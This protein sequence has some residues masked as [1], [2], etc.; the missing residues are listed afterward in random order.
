MT[1]GSDDPQEQ[2]SAQARTKDIDRVLENI[3]KT[4]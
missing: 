3:L 1:P 2:S 4:I